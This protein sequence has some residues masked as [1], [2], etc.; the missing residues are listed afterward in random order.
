VAP[1]D[2]AKS[3]RMRV[4]SLL[5]GATALLGGSALL[6]LVPPLPGGIYPPCL[7]H[8][9]TGLHCPGCGSTRCLHALLHGELRQAAAFNVLLLIAVPFLAY[10]GARF[11]WSGP[12]SRH[13]PVWIVRVILIIVIAFWV[14]RNIPCAP[15]NLL[16]PH[17]L[18]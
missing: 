2:P 17:A 3:A 18:P 6:Y 5:T 10:C 11:L 14:L 4:V 7:F 15:F 1:V 12:E 16:A 8:A 13:L 9:L